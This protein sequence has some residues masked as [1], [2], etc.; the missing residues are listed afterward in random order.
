MR[1]VA[2]VVRTVVC[3]LLVVSDRLVVFLLVFFSHRMMEP[4]SFVSGR[5]DISSVFLEKT[6]DDKHNVRLIYSRVAALRGRGS[7]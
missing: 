4:P 2:L 3:D 1:Y 6:P 7:Q 5:E